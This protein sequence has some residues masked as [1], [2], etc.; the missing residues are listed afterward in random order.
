M[1]LSGNWTA[2]KLIKQP[3]MLLRCRKNKRRGSVAKKTNTFDFEKSLAELEQLVEK[4]EQGELGLEESL[5]YFERGVALTRACQQALAAA[6]KRVQI[7]TANAGQGELQPF[8]PSET[9]DS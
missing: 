9:P 1:R 8:D 7:L 2:G 5:K 6:E 4:M 3:G